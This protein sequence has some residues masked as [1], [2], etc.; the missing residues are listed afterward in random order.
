MRTLP[1]PVS[2]GGRVEP[3]TKFKKRGG[4]TGPQ[5]LDGGCWERGGDFFQG[6]GGAIVTYK[7]KSEIFN[8]KRS[9]EAKIF[10]FVI[11]KNSNWEISLYI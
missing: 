5:L 7:L 3:T 9:L 10:F 8:D 2:A 4:L 1:A 6:G 11:T